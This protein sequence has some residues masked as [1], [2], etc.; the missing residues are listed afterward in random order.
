[1]REIKTERKIIRANSSD[2]KKTALR[3]KI[4]ALFF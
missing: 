2:S 1:M 4:Q 3:Q